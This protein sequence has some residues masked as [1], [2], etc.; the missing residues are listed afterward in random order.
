MNRFRVVALVLVSLGGPVS[1][2]VDPVQNPP[3]QLPEY[4]IKAGFL[5]NFAKYVEWPGASFEGPESPITIGIVGADPFGDN[6]EKSLSH[7]TVNKR[8]FVIRRYAAPSDLGRCHILFVSRSEKART[9][10]IIKQVEGQPVLTVGEDGAFAAS[11]GM[12]AILIENEKPRLE[13]N[14][15]AAETAKLT[16][17]SKLLKLATIVKT[18]K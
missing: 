12:I 16:I 2:S 5:F 17:N 3:D 4:V 10:E 9:S 8:P 18:V 6:L 11:G 15:E 13:V 1:A 14:P 7:K